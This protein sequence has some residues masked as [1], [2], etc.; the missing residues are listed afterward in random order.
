MREK[1]CCSDE[2]IINHL[3]DCFFV[4]LQNEFRAPVLAVLLM[5][6]CTHPAVL[7]STRE[8]GG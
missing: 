4:G 8:R 2:T 5:P 6:C 3:I 1:L 7:T